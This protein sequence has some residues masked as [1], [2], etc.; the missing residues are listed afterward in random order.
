VPLLQWYTA[1][2]QRLTWTDRFVGRRFLEV[3]HLTET[4]RVLFHPYIVYRALAHGG[5]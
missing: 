5:A 4:P 2:V 3:M 1:R